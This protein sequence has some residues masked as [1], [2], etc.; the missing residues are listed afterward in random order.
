M[1]INIIGYYGKNF[2]DLLMLQ[3]MLN[4]YIPKGCNINILSYDSLNID[5]IDITNELNINVY[6]I[7]QVSLIKLLR[8]YRNADKMIWGGGSCFNDVDGTG[9]VKQMLLAKIVHPSISIEYY[10]VGIDLKH[11]KYNIY[12]MKIALKICSSFTVRDGASYEVV[13]NNKKT[14]LCNDP[15]FL[16]KEWLEELVPAKEHISDIIISYR[17]VDSYYREKAP[18]FLQQFIDNIYTLIRHNKS[19]SNVIIFDA[20]SSIDSDNNKCI[21]ES[22]RKWTNVHVKYIGHQRPSDLCKYIRGTKMVIT[23]RLHVAVLAHLYLKE[24]AL[25]NYSKKNETF[26]KSHNRENA[27]VAYTSLHNPDCIKKIF[28]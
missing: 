18:L 17:C 28:E 23:G 21:Y 1:T 3:S 5:V 12:C 9:A 19:L 24:V 6:H 15:I 26:L 14:S 4:M 2:G 11:N 7:N 13:K 10:G 27:L 22:M 20:D 8:L 25:L 16:I